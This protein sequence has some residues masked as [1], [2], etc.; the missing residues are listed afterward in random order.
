ML[1]C[2]APF[3]ELDARLTPI[4]AANRGFFPMLGHI[5]DLLIG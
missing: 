5:L 1:C 2:G 3:L 4:A